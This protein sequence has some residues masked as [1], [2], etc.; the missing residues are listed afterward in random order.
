M[1]SGEISLL[2]AF[3]AG[4]LSF[5]SPCVLPLVP[6]YLT[7]LAGNQVAGNKLADDRLDRLRLFGHA[8]AFV[9]GFTLIFVALWVAVGAVGYFVQG[10]YDYLRIAG[11]VVLIVFGLHELGLFQIPALY[12]ERRFYLTNRGRASLPVSF[13][14]GVVFA[15]G[16]TPCIGPVLAGIIGLATVRGTLIEGTVLLTAYSLGLG[17]PFLLT[18][19]ALDRATRVLR[20]LG[21]QARLVTV[22]S[23]LLLIAVGVLMLTNM[24]VL[25]PR[26]FQWAAL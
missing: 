12:R 13:L 3:A 16:W 10:Y 18:A 6:A 21:R 9:L 15:A 7:H 23:G 11:G 22:A 17:V 14:I 26:Y 25:L 20:R 24:F 5:L 8:V 4:I 2:I 19:V 1:M